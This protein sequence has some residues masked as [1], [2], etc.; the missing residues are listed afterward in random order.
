M[1]TM[2]NT[3][4][5][6][7]FDEAAFDRKVCEITATIHRN[8]RNKIFDNSYDKWMNQNIQH[9]EKMYDITVTVSGVDCDFLDFCKWVFDNSK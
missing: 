2:R 6:K 3:R 4:T 5:K 9:L 1:K 8:A 7:K